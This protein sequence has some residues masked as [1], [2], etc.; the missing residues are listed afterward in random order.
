MVRP[1][2][3]SLVPR[4]HSGHFTPT[5]SPGCYIPRTSPAPVL[6]AYSIQKW[7]AIDR[8]KAFPSTSWP[9]HAG[10]R[11]SQLQYIWLPWQHIPCVGACTCLLPCTGSE[12]CSRPGLEQTRW[13]PPPV[14]WLL[15]QHGCLGWRSGGV[16]AGDCHPLHSR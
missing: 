12:V 8:G 2:N 11:L 3:V 6:V 14:E 7:T 1:V 15:E 9:M 4:P 16:Y 10:M 13:L 5:L